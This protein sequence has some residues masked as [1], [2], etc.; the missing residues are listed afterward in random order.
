M[1]K[2]IQNV[3]MIH[4]SMLNNYSLVLMMHP[5][6]ILMVNSHGILM[7]NSHGLLHSPRAIGLMS[8]SAT[9]ATLPLFASFPL[10]DHLVR[11]RFNYAK[12]GRP[13]RNISG[14]GAIYIFNSRFRFRFL[15]SLVRV[16]GRDEDS[17]RPEQTGTKLKIV[18]V[19]AYN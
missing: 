2:L 12:S 1:Y 16:N 9:R 15:T 10:W 19:F 5:R 14:C 11:S 7:V 4:Y 6:G 18:S 17:I 13:P 8:E 3:S